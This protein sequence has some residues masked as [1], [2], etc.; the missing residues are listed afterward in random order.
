[1]ER[2][3]DGDDVHRAVRER[4]PLGAALEHARARHIGGEPR[5]HA[6]QRLDGDHGTA[7]GDERGRELA[8]TRREVEHA[9][10]GREPGLPRETVERLVRV[11]GTRHGVRA[12]GP[13][14]RLG[15]IVALRVIVDHSEEYDTAR[16]STV[17]A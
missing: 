4:D 11:A 13:V 1:M 15:A 6:R 10:A 16:G 3:T 12:D 5:A 7:A 9:A 17:S 2:L 14:E 8:R